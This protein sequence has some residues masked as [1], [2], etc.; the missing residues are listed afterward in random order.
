MPVLLPEETEERKNRDKNTLEGM[1]CEILWPDAADVCSRCEM[2]TTL[3]SFMVFL[4]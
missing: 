4:L 2:P 3:K 1:T